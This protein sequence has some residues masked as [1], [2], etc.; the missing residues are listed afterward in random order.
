MVQDDD[1]DFEGMSVQVINLCGTTFSTAQ[2]IKDL[3]HTGS[4]EDTVNRIFDG[5][6][7]IGIQSF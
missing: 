7:R 3:R 1:L 5:L 4:V 6:V 2:I